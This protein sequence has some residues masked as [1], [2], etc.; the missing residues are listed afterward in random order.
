MESGKVMEKL[1]NERMQAYLK[2]MAALVNR[3]L[4]ESV[5]SKSSDRYV[6]SLLGRSGYVYDHRAI[7]KG[8]LEPARYL[9]GIGGKRLRAVLTLAV[10]EALGKNP[11]DY[12]E[13]ALV[14]EVVHNGTLIHDDIED[15]SEVR[16]GHATVHAKYG[17][18]IGVNLGDFL[19][20]FPVVALI[21]SKKLTSEAKNRALSVYV[22][23]MLRLSVGQAM[24]LAWHNQSVGLSE[25]TE[26]QYIQTIANKTGSAFSMAAQLGGI[27]AGAEDRVVEA[28]GKFGESLGIAFQIR[29]DALNISE[30]ALA[31][32]KGGIGDDIKEGKVT[33]M[34]VRALRDSSA[35]DRARLLGILRAHSSAKKAVS[36][37][38]GILRK[39]GADVHA[40]S[41][42]VKFSD[43]ALSAVES[44][45]PESEAKEWLA[46]LARFA[47]SRTS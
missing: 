37:Y 26:E 6:N 21:S 14:P 9:L 33:L 22:R 28:L 15:R 34:V 2:D 12:V 4:E 20:F 35:A 13:F 17:L 23:E 8:I 47:V 30:S 19:Y 18:D 24:D 16:R 46:W 42:A 25:I 43:E 44:S 3:K 40:Q 1:K 32:N 45:L 38:I 7:D 27:V 10:I 36:D 29:D 39:C 41:V 31:A 11:A 5:E